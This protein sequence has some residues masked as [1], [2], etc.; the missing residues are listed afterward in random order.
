MLVGLAQ[1]ASGRRMKKR[2]IIT[3][4]VFAG[5]H[6]MLAVG[7]LF[8]ALFAGSTAFDYPE[9]KL[10]VIARV[11]FPLAQVLAQPGES[12]VSTTSRSNVA[13]WGLWAANSLVWG[14]VLALI[15]S[16]PAFLKGKI[17]DSNGVLQR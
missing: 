5:I 12:F 7:S 15:L 14:V 4:L 17:S 11:A 3:A 1:T 16:I 6:F 13:Q 9:S 2:I 8:V 10:A